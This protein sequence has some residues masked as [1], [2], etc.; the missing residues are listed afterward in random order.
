MVT[1]TLAIEREILVA[2]PVERVWDVLTNPRHVAHW[3]GEH[4]EIEPRPGGSARFEWEGHG[5]F[6]ATVVRFDPPGH[7]AY[8]WANRA[9][10]EP[11]AGSSTLVEFTLEPSGNG[12]RL[13]VV[14][15]GFETL[16]LPDAEQRRAVEENTQGWRNELDE[17]RVY[18]EQL[19]A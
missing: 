3:F 2:A 17:L 18:A 12:T 11:V 13:R 16:T 10:D 1:A 4:A 5:V 14:E 6:K 8:R 15:S 19:T 9:G 7:F